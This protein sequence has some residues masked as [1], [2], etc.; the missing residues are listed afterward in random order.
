MRAL[1]IRIGRAFAAARRQHAEADEPFARLTRPRRRDVL[2]QHRVKRFAF[3]RFHRV[4]Q[5]REQQ[6][7]HGGAQLRPMY[8]IVRLPVWTRGSR[9]IGRP[10]LTASMPV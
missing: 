10:L 2:E 7:K 6:A 9:K 5:I 8:V 4:E 3:D 1:R